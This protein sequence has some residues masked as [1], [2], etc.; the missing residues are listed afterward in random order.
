MTNATTLQARYEAAASAIKTAE[1]KN[2][3]ARTMSKLYKAL[4]LVEDE[5]KAAGAL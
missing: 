2:R 5:A 1:A 4:F 3:C